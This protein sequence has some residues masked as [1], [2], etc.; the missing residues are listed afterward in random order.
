MNSIT[1]T[2][3]GIS[4]V[5]LGGS[6]RNE[7]RGLGSPQKNRSVHTPERPPLPQE[8][9]SGRDGGSGFYRPKSSSPSCR[10]GDRTL[11]TEPEMGKNRDSKP[12]QTEKRLQTA[13]RFQYFPNIR[14]FP[15]SGCSSRADSARSRSVFLSILT[16]QVPTAMR[17]NVFKHHFYNTR[18]KAATALPLEMG[19]FRDSEHS[20]EFAVG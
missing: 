6:W 10:R 14:T 17:T 11:P 9:F 16:N 7:Q 2:S 1:S 12:P 3:T 15:Q 4:K 5:C 13:H 8:W 20:C 18:V 19:F